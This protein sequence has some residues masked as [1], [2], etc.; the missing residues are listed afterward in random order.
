MKNLVKYLAGVLVAMGLVIG[1][2]AQ[3]NLSPQDLVQQTAD[4]M[5]GK[6]KEER[7]VIAAEPQRIYELVNEIV[8]PH[9]DF[10]YMSQ[11][12]V[13]KHWRGASAEQ[14]NKFVGE[15]RTLLVRTYATSLNQY[16]DQQI[17]YL[18]S[19]DK[20]GADEATVRTEIEQPGTFPIPIDYKLHLKDS[21]W[22]VFDVVIDG[23]SMVTNYRTTFAKEIR[24]GGMDALIASLAERNEKGME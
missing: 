13:G 16:V 7:A 2:P 6:L 17:V 1:M 9:F 14:R 19:R 8:L 24:A 23:V 4:R 15:F 18:P 3:A 10:E 22:I 20:A 21:K 11:L 5:L 12:V